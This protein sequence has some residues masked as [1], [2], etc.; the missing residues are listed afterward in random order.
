[1]L[2]LIR[3]EGRITIKV[4]G[5]LEGPHAEELR[6]TVC[7]PSALDVDVSGVTSIDHD[8]ERALVWLRERGATLLGAE[9]LAGRLC[10]EL[11]IEQSTLT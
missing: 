2:S 9:R 4:T 1:M 8:G 7:P 11:R 10:S 5:R 3:H 6:L